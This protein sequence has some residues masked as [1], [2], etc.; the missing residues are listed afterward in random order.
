MAGITSNKLAEVRK[1]FRNAADTMIIPVV[2]LDLDHNLA[3]AN[4]SA[5]QMLGIGPEHLTSG[6][7]VSDI[8]APEQIGL[9]KEGLT[10][11]RERV[12]STPLTLKVKTLGGTEIFVDTIADA[13]IVNKKVEGFVVYVFDL[14]RR[15]A[16]EEKIRQREGIFEYIVEQSSFAGLFVVG[17]N[18]RFEYVN[19]KMAD[20]LG[21]TRSEILGHDFRE[22]LHP[23]SVELVADRY[24]RRQRG[25]SVP[26]IYEF[27]IIRGDGAVRK[28]RLSSTVTKTGEGTAKTIAQMVDITEEMERQQA[29]KESEQRYRTLVETMDSGFCVDNEDGIAIMVNQ[30]LVDMLGFDSVDDL[31]GESVTLW[32]LDMSEEDLRKKVDLRKQGVAEHYEVKLIHKTGRIIPA[33]VHASPVFD[34][35]GTYIG[36][37]AIFTDISELKAAEAEARFLLDLLLHDIGNQMQLIMAG[38]DMLERGSTPEQVMRARQYVLDGAKRCL[39]LI[40]NIRHTE[41]AKSEP[42]RPVDLTKALR[43]EIQVFSGQYMMKPEVSGLSESIRVYADSALGHLFWNLMENSIKHNKKDEKKLWITGDRDNGRFIV[44][45]EDNGPGLVDRKKDALFDPKARASGVGLHLV[46]RIITKYGGQLFVE[47]RVPGKPDE[48]LRMSI[49]FQIAT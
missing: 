48:G 32:T 5:Q 46:R 34:I 8:I 2:E 23:D 4:N 7:N 18:Y 27:E 43:A 21:R 37:L 22:F 14:T 19:D 44:H 17:G 36:S 20:I 12:D 39:A 38:A 11:L 13:I 30:S 40:N 33:I 35:E 10:R 9:A 25:E 1:D 6:L 16:L 29:L 47:D 15:M 45:F 49:Q 26:S 28:V 42:V 3:Y 41:E 31:T 24:R